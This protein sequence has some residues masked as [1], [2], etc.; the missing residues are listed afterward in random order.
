MVMTSINDPT[1]T[2]NPTNESSGDG[3]LPSR[4]GP[5]RFALRDDG[6][7][8][9]SLEDADERDLSDREIVS[10]MVLSKEEAG[11]VRKAAE[12][13]LSASASSTI[14]HL[15]KRPK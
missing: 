11:R 4:R 3:P 1:E 2:S 12:D 7:L 13:A 15:P 9:L 6:A 5:S 8:L 10:F 14:G